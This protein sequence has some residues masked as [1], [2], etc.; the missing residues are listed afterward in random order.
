MR[1]LICSSLGALVSLSCAAPPPAADA[2]A[3]AAAASAPEPQS[4]EWLYATDGVPGGRKGECRAVVERLEKEASCKGA[5]CSHGAA[6]A[7]DWLRVCKSL[8]P[9]L[10]GAVEERASQLAKSA[11]QQAAPCESEVERLLTQGCDGEACG[12]K[13]QA[14]AT[15]CSEWSTPLV[16]RMLEVR[17]E[18]GGGERLRLDARGCPELLAQ[19]RKAGACTQQFACQDGFPAIDTY[20]A[21]CVAAGGAP[22]PTAGV[23]ELAVRAGAAQSLEPLAIAE[24]GKLDPALVPLGFEDGSGAVVMTCGQRATSVEAYLALRKSCADG[25]LV[26]ARRFDG[27]KGPV[28]RVGRLPHLGD[29]AFL[30][31]FPSL[32]V[33]G[34]PRARYQAALPGFLA[35]VDQAA[36]AASDPKRVTEATRAFV[37]ALN[38]NIDA[39]RNSSAF[40]TALKEKDA[41]LV[42]L[43]AGIG[44]AKRKL[45]QGDLPT[46]KLAPGMQRG[47]SYPLADVD[48]QGRVRLGAVTVAASVELGDL[49]PKADAAYQERL[50]GRWKLLEK[51][52]LGQN[53]ANRLSQTADA[54]ASRC[55]QAMKAV[56]GSEKSILDCAFGIEV[57]DEA[58]IVG[59]VQKSM[60]ARKDAELAWPKATLALASLAR[61]QRAG[62]EKAA[63]LAGCREPWW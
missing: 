37:A 62:A 43:F 8:T 17:V 60:Q 61:D 33:E 20:R 48:A 26:L 40:E 3:V 49:F 24:T 5:L 30:T 28:L 39:V 21:R 10:A 46:G 44:E 57:C 56:E 11:A 54:E 12:A 27:P 29:A 1:T 16:V 7:K 14:W 38:D 47:K 4:S 35:A 9:E 50:S 63:E 53:E 13:A 36:R 18:R 34:E 31:G 23:L 32:R 52:R 25:E 55:G 42:P 59:A 6:L 41:T 58:K 2:P 51:K 22:S 45:F 19:V 15:R